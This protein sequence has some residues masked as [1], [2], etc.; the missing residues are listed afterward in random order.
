[1]YRFHLARNLRSFFFLIVVAAVMTGAGVLWWA[2]RTGLPTAWREVIERE[3]Q[4]KGAFVKIGALSYHPF[5]G[6]M[7]SNV[8]VFSDA[9]C[10]H[11]VS[12]LKTVL[13]AFDKAKLARRRRYHKN[14]ASGCRPTL[15]VNPKDPD[16]NLS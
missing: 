10:T 1:M 7:A 9:S 16:Q 2:N 15:P 8:R 5:R 14:R 4:K 12:R 11:E 3:I 13:L 6:V